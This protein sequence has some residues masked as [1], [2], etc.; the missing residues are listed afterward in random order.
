MVIINEKY[1]FKKFI[2]FLINYDHVI[3]NFF[4]F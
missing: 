1:N 2:L 4:F 3:F